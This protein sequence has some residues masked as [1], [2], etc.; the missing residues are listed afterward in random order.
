MS[1]AVVLKAQ[2]IFFL[3]LS[4]NPLDIKAWQR[5]SKDKEKVVAGVREA[6]RIEEIGCN[7][8]FS[9]I[10]FST[11]SVSAVLVLLT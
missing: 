2:K 6:V 10:S 5:K 8:G 7:S 11:A 3:S 4:L 9:D 1:F